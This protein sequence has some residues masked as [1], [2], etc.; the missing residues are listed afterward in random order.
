MDGIGD[1]ISTMWMESKLFGDRS[2]NYP[3]R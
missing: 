2:V 1:I 3:H